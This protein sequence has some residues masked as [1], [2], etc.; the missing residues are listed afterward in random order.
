MIEIEIPGFKKLQLKYLVMDYNGTLAI[1]GKLIE[2]VENR[3]YA[4]ADH[5]EI[6]VITADTFGLVKTYLENFPIQ[7]KIITSTEQGKQK[8][9][10]VRQLGSGQVVAIGNGRNDRLML[11][12]AKLGIA[13]IQ[14]EGSAMETIQSADIVVNHINDALDLLREKL[15]LTATLRD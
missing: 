15:R 1:D 8:W 14:A 10:Y 4:L 13:T 5:L 12:E 11:K 3:L 2:G 6:H 9:Q 7:L